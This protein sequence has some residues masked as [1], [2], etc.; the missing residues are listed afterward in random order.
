MTRFWTYYWG[1]QQVLGDME[2]T[3]RTGQHNYLD[4]TGGSGFVS[5]GISPGD[6]LYILNYLDGI[7]GVLGRM[8]VGKVMDRACAAA[9]LGEIFDAPEHITAQPDS[10]TLEVFDAVLRDDQVDQLE[11]LD[12][13]GAAVAAKRNASGEVEPQ[14]FRNVR[15]VSASTA[16]LFD[17][18][19][20]FDRDRFRVGDQI[21]RK[22][23]FGV[24]VQNDDAEDVEVVV[25]LQCT[26]SGLPG[27]FVD[28]SHSTDDPSL[29]TEP[30]RLIDLARE[31]IVRWVEEF[32]FV[33]A[34]DQL[35]SELAA[36][37]NGLNVSG[38][39]HVS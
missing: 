9:E 24:L 20:G 15:E 26:G 25:D 13:K 36:E 32:Q 7:P 16:E 21:T 30:G 1:G 33:I 4:Y 6:Q 17:S 39:D 2:F 34:P 8:T 22:V 31:L 19:L 12:K 38:G 28:L 23:T 3:D 37:L 35:E 27:R 29:L 10:G 11:F 14:T 5:A 18:V